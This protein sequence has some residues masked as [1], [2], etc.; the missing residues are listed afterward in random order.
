MD[1]LAGSNVSA[2]VNMVC[3]LLRNS[4][5]KAVVHCQVREAKRSLLDHFYAQVGKREVDILPFSIS[6]CSSKANHL[7]E[8]DAVAQNGVKTPSMTPTQDGKLV[9]YLCLCVVPHSEDCFLS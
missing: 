3:E 6:S 2:Y 8:N 4:L 7:A 5:P 9:V 1:I